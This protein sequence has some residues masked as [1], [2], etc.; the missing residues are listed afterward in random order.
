MI[1]MDNERNLNDN[2]WFEE[3]PLPVYSSLVK[4]VLFFHNKTVLINNKNM[5]GITSSEELEWAKNNE[6]KENQPNIYLERFNMGQINNNFKRSCR[7]FSAK[8]L[9]VSEI[10]FLL[11]S[12]FGWDKDSFGKR[13]PSAGALYP[14][15]PIFYLF[16]EVATDNNKLPP[17][18]YMYK[19]DTSDLYLL[20]RI[21][22]SELAQFLQVFDYNFGEELPSKYC[23]GYSL[24]IKKAVSKYKHRGY[25]H[26]LI[27]AGA[28]AQSF[29]ESV[30]ELGDIGE[31]CSSAFDDFKVTWLSDLNVRE[32]PIVLLQWFGKRGEE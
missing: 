1:A 4:E 11:N 28:L 26:G 27:E 8:K 9:T 14:I 7:E 2:L 25:R 21:S 18:V 10:S 19:G 12:S 6:F 24:N 16:E 30:K 3:Y 13:Y 29:R 20:K 31:F 23:I 22:E 5:V 32:A 17:G 15:T